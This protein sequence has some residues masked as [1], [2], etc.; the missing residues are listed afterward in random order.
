MD[1]N[2]FQRLTTS[3]LDSHANELELAVENHTRWVNNISRTLLC[4]GTPDAADLAAAPHLLCHFGRWYHG[5]DNPALLKLPEFETIGPVHEAMHQAARELLLAQQE[6]KPFD[7]ATYDRLLHLSDEMRRQLNR[8]RSGFKHNMNLISLLMGKVFENATEGVLI[9]DP[10]GVIL[11]VNHAFTEF[12]GYT[13][14]EAIGKTPALLRSGR[15]S[16]AFYRHMW[17]TLQN[18]GQWEGEIWNRRKDGKHYL[19]WL[20]ISGVRDDTGAITH[21]VAVFSDITSEKENE[22]RLYHLAHY[23]LL[24]DLPNRMLFYDRLRQGLLRARR[25]KRQVAVMFLDLDGF[26]QV[27]DELGHPAGDELL[28]QVARRL[29]GLLRASDTVARFGGDE[30]TI[31]L[32]DLAADD[33]IGRVAQKIIE[34]VAKPCYLGS[35]RVQVTTSVGI[36][37]FPQDGEDPDTLITHADMAM[38]EAKKGGKNSYRFYATP[39]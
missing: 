33:D 3:E 20:T 8:L 36:S 30:F 17:L 26:K 11:S 18:E 34:A 37:L 38:Y 15:Q 22:E 35:N 23:D 39:S 12:T 21:Y 9:T 19:E 10:N 28:R 25:N 4:H 13:A 6:G 29:S 5:I 31:S 27:N 16:E 14:E 24:T 32:P 2:L 1:K 7:V